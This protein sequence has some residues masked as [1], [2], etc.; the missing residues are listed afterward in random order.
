M[1]S[2]LLWGGITRRKDEVTRRKITLISRETRYEQ[3]TT[4]QIL[5]KILI[6]IYIVH[7]VYTTLTVPKHSSVQ[8]MYDHMS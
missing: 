6:Y 3:I 5:H 7:I 2:L 4:S 8:R 1:P